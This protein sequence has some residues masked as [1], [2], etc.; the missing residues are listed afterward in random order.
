MKADG[1][2]RLYARVHAGL[3]TLIAC[4]LPPE[5]VVREGVVRTAGCKK[6]GETCIGAAGHGKSRS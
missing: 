5:L 2:S 4:R 3:R 1:Q 6:I